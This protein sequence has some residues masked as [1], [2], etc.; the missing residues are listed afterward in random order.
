MINTYFSKIDDVTKI[1]NKTKN[2]T[3]E[4]KT[5]NDEFQKKIE[6]TKI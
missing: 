1:T 6:S 3:N 2:T 4:I 5:T